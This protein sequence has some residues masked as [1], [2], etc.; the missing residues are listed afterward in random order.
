MATDGKRFEVYGIV[1]F[2]VSLLVIFSL[3]SDPKV[4]V[5]IE[6]L[7]RSGGF[8]SMFLAGAFYSDYI[9]GPAATAVIFYMGKVQHPLLVASV[10]AFGTMCA[11]Y[12]L[13]RFI[14]K[15]AKPSIKFISKKLKMGGHMKKIFKTMAPVAAA[16]IIASPLPDELGVA[17]LGAINFKTKYFFAFSYSLNFIGILAISWL[18]SV[19]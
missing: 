17:I 19:L 18:G 13:F 8:I 16:V 3:L 12:L 9:T 11:D 14:K 7:G 4:I 6:N 1:F 2:F 5:F 10:G 15:R